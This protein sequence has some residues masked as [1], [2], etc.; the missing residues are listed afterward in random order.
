MIDGGPSQRF[1]ITHRGI[2]IFHDMWDVGSNGGESGVGG[3]A[4]QSEHVW[5]GGSHWM[6]NVRSLRWI[7]DR[8]D[9]EMYVA[10][11]GPH[12]AARRLRVSGERWSVER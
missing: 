8:C 2:D 6:Y 11:R 1:S 9:M 7:N 10:G 3:R 12:A 5:T 4:R